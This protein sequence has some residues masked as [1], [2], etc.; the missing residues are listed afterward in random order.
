MGGAPHV[1]RG[2]PGSC[3]R[4]AVA[5]QVPRHTRP[6][7]AR[8]LSRQISPKKDARRGEACGL[9]AFLHRGSVLLEA[10][11][12][13]MCPAEQTVAH[14]RPGSKMLPRSGGKG[15]SCGTDGSLMATGA[16]N[17]MWT[18]SSRPVRKCHT[19]RDHAKL[20]GRAGQG[21]ELRLRRPVAP[22]RSPSDLA[23]I[24][25]GT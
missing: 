5:G 25:P 4:A 8:E 7:R 13:A 12:C 9:R 1:T 14:S 6:C 16:A 24:R 19:N 11:A 3:C 18:P 10:T 21:V 2:G 23:H 20:H 15:Q 22:V 17:S